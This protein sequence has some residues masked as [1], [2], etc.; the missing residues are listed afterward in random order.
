MPSLPSAYLLTQVY[1]SHP[2][3]DL[4]KQNEAN[5]LLT[6]TSWNNGSPVGTSPWV[7]SPPFMEVVASEKENKKRNKVCDL[8]KYM[9]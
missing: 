6:S 3:K 4:N 7:V 1:Y 9:M 2:K 5:N 8:G